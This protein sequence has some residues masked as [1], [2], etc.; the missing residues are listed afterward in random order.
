MRETAAA[1]GLEAKSN[2]VI[3]ADSDHGSGGVR[4]DYDFQSVW[5]GSVFDC[6]LRLLQPFPPAVR[7]LTRVLTRPMLFLASPLEAV[8]IPDE[9]D[10]KTRLARL[11]NAAEGLDNSRGK[12]FMA[13]KW[14][15]TTP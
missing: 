11:F 4:S 12:R 1:L 2:F 5:Y 3:H 6:D 13:A 9:P 14:A 10:D 15:A 7:V 8:K